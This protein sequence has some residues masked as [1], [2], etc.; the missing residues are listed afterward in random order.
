MPRI[1]ASGQLRRG[2]SLVH[3]WAFSWLFVLALSLWPAALGEAGRG[4]WSVLTE[5]F[6]VAAID[7]FLARLGF[8]CFALRDAAFVLWINAGRS[9]RAD[10]VGFIYLLVLYGPVLVLFLSME[11]WSAAALIAPLPFGPAGLGIASALVQ[12]VVLAFLTRR[13]WQALFRS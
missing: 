13:R 8:V 12:A 4:F 10:L 2:L 9:Q 11:A 1:L 3:W 7:P 6:G 5:R